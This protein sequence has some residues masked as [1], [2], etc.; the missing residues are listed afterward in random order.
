MT[1]G[2]RHLCALCAILALC[3]SPLAAGKPAKFQPLGQHPGGSW[4]VAYAVSQDGQV[5]VGYGFNAEG[6]REA[7]RWT[8]RDGIVGLGFLNPNIGNRYSLA[9]D[10]S[11]D[12]SVIVGSSRYN[13]WWSAVEGFRWTEEKGMVG[14]GWLDDP[15][16]LRDSSQA[17]GV[18]FDGSVIVGMAGEIFSYT[19]PVKWTED[20]GIILLEE[21]PGAYWASRTAAVSPDGRIATGS[22][23][24]GDHITY[25]FKRQACWWTEEGEM[26]S[27]GLLSGYYEAEGMALSPDGTWIVGRAIGEEFAEAFRW[28]RQGAKEGLGWPR[29]RPGDSEASAV[30]R[31]GQVVVGSSW[32]PEFKG[33]AFIWTER[34]GNR[35]LQEVLENE[36]GLDLRGWTLTSAN[37]ITEDGRFIVG[38]GVNGDGEREAFLVDLGDWDPLAD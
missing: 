27:L 18:S 23:V 30:A 13:Y 8:K 24:L 28:S 4:S 29:G 12:G 16:G 35:L 25:N 38:E 17:A 5:V 33:E 6:P 7:F 22:T 3:C 19:A 36:V 26:R 32:D 11:A 37:D 31:G 34:D 1:R 21:V 2:I 14:L 15:P 20:D 10:V 9:M